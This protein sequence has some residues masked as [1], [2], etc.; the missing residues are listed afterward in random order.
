MSHGPV[1]DR[2]GL[3]PTNDTAAIRRAYAA[4]IRQYRPDSHPAEFSQIREAYEV[5][6]QL[7][8]DEPAPEAEPAPSPDRLPHE[9][10]SAPAVPAAV[11]AQADAPAV[12]APVF[13]APSLIQALHDC[14]RDAGDEAARGLLHEQVAWVANL[15]IDAKLDYEAHLLH[16]LLSS[17][18]PPPAVVFEGTRLLRWSERRDDIVQMFGDGGAQRLGLLMEM[19]DEYT[20]ARHFSSNR[21]Q[22]RLFEAPA[23]AAPRFGSVIHVLSGRATADYWARLCAAG[24]MP[25]LEGRLNSRVMR[26]LHGPLL[27]SS[28][29]LMALLLGVLAWL[30]IYDAWDKASWWQA[31]AA[32]ALTTAVVLPL[33]AASR[34]FAGTQIFQKLVRVRQLFSGIPVGVGAVAVFVL[35]FLG[36]VASEPGNRAGIRYPAMAALVLFAALLLSAIAVGLWGLVCYLDKVV[37]ARWLALQRAS[38]IHAFNL[39]R[40]SR[41]PGWLAPTWRGRLRL[42]PGV[43]M[44]GWAGRKHARQAS[45]QRKRESDARAAAAASPF[46]SSSDSSFSWWWVVVGLI[47]LSNLFRAATK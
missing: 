44:A 30:Q 16:W 5:A 29:V 24:G 38:D 41:E 27:L 35:V 19:A 36:F 23:A 2:L 8:R 28:D 1:W 25:D 39:V 18:A 4:L 31:W 12:S 47:V 43:V 21:W 7:A 10:E 20:Y 11:P 32:A 33:P 26:A 40:Q 37:M 6:M 22:R 34:W 3:E 9:P 46:S 42:L 15:T 17:D 45:A 14:Q 13:D